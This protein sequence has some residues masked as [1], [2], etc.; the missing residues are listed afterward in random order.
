MTEKNYVEDLYLAVRDYVVANGGS[1]VSADGIQV[2]DWLDD[3]PDCYRVAIK[4]RGRLPD[5]ART[6]NEMSHVCGLGL[7]NLCPKRKSCSC[8]CH[9]DD[10]EGL[11]P[12]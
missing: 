9:K 4:C 12:R 1:L 8:S 5:F 2:Q 6:L 3:G 10:V 11:T 7:H